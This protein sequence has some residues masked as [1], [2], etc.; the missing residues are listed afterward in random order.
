[1]LLGKVVTNFIRNPLVLI[2]QNSKQFTLYHTIFFCNFYLPLP[3]SC[4]QDGLNNNSRSCYM[5]CRITTY[6]IE[7]KFGI[8][9][10]KTSFFIAVI[11]RVWHTL[12]YPLDKLHGQFQWKTGCTSRQKQLAFTNFSVLLPPSWQPHLDTLQSVLY[13]RTGRSQRQHAI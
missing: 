3:G 2:F 1:M 4:S 7:Y 5:Y 8:K 9:T 13:F 10:D 12:A 6:L 11:W